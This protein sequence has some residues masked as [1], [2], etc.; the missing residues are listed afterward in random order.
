MLMSHAVINTECKCMSEHVCVTDRETGLAQ[1]V[2]TQHS[3]WKTFC[4]S[5]CW[6]A[7]VDV[8]VCVYACLHT[9][10]IHACEWTGMHVDGCT[11]CVHDTLGLQ[12]NWQIVVMSK[13]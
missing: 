3:R 5:A 13:R 12:P 1:R 8:L 2:K 10:W 7:R 9:V 6:P 4:G 11:V